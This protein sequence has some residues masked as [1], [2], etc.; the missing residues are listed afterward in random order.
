MGGAAS[1]TIEMAEYLQKIGLNI[2]IAG[3]LNEGEAYI[4]NGVTY[5]HLGS[6]YDLSHHLPILAKEDFDVIQV[7]RGGCL[8]QVAEFFPRAKKIVRLIDVFFGSHKTSASV[9]NE[10]AD[11][12]IA[13]SS[14]VKE[15][16]I[17]W[18]VKEEKITIIPVGIRT[19]LFCSIPE[20]S[21][22]KKLLVFSGATI[23][24]KGIGILL[25]AFV[26]LQAHIPD[27]KLEVYGSANLWSRREVIPW[28]EIEQKFP[29]MISY[30]GETSKAELAIALNRAAICIVPSLVPEGFTRASIEAQAC[31][32]PIVCSAAGGL[33]ETLIDGETGYIIKQITHENLANKLESMLKDKNCLEIMSRKAAEYAQ[34]FSVENSAF[35]FMQ[36]LS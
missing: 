15:N 24:E 13:V 9:I 29:H 22:D 30:K 6:N 35:A 8:P 11:E 21:R 2:T 31:G 33:P 4:Q 1:C 3:I 5:Y 36:V 7:L 14:Y 27:A 20:I 26:T 12:V 32:C 23:P 34:M 19:D 18:G 17:K 25:K 10:M 16:A 28:Q